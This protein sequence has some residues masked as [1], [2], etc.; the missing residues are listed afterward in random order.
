MRNRIIKIDQTASNDTWVTLAD[1]KEW[2]IVEHN[3]DDALLTRLIK[4]VRIAFEKWTK[5]CIVDSVVVVTAEINCGEFKLPRLPFKEINSVDIRESDNSFTAMSTDDY[6][7]LGNSILFE[8][9]GII[10]IDYNASW[11]GALPDDIKIAGF[12]EI[13]LRYEN[14]GDVKGESGFSQVAE[15]YLLP[16]VNMSYL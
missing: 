4:A 8:K 10:R 9:K 2:L 14:R 7:V 3:E 16:Y 11:N 5:M 1:V 12:S 15:T 6:T 13:A